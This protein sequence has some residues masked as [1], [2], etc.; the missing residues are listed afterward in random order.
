[1]SDDENSNVSGE[2]AE[3]NEEVED[4]GEEEEPSNEPESKVVSTCSFLTSLK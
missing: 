2:V 4:A 3:E 1:M